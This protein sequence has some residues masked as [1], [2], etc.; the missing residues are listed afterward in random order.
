MTKQRAGIH[1]LRLT[2]AGVDFVQNFRILIKYIIIVNYI[3]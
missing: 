3:K 1:F 2:L